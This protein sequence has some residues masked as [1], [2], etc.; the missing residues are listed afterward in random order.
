MADQRNITFGMSFGLNEANEQI[1]NIINNLETVKQDMIFVEQESDE[2]GTRIG[3]NAQ[4]AGN[5]LKDAGAQ[6]ATAGM[7]I[8]DSANA[9]GDAWKSIGSNAESMSAAII[10]SA[11]TAIKQTNSI[12]STVKAGLE[13]A[14]GYSE[15]RFKSFTTSMTTGMKKIATIAKNP[16]QTIKDGL[17]GALEKAR[18][19]LEDVEDEADKTGN[20]MENV[21]KAGK[22]TGT[23]IKTAI[24]GA[25]GKLVALKAGFELIKKGIEATKN[26]ASTLIEAGTSADTL[27][28]KFEAV[29]ANDTGVK[30]WSENFAAGINRSKSE[31]QEFLVSNKALYAELGITGETATDLSKVTTSL[32]YDLGA[33]FKMDDAEA[34]SVLQDYISGNTNALAEYGI[35]IDDAILKQSALQMGISSNI[36]E[37]SD[38]EA[39]QIRMNALLE[40]STSIQ[41][42]AANGELGYANGTKAITAKLTDLKETLGTKFEPIFTKVVGKI[43]ELW[44]KIEPMVISLFDNMESGLEMAAPA[45]LDLAASALPQVI[46]AFSQ[47][48]EA[49]APIGSVLLNLATTALP[50]LLKA[51]GPVAS[52][53]ASLATTILPPLGSIIG[54]LVQTVI[55]PFVEIVTMI[56]EKAITPLMPLVGTIADAILPVIESGLQALLPI[57]GAVLP[58]LEPICTVIGS[59]V[60][61]LGKIAAYAASGIGTVIEKVAGLFNGNGSTESIELPHNALGT[62][63]FQGGWTHIN[64]QGGEVAYLPGGSTIIP[65]DKSQQLI[66]NM[67]EQSGQNIQVSISM[68]VTISGNA[69]EKTLNELEERMHKIIKEDAAEIFKKEQDKQNSKI[70]IQEGYT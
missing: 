36:D 61:F 19:S 16:I 27:K 56:T 52:A 33:A 43:L 70:A 18:E 9:A 45:L 44:P 60:E 57:L 41:Q 10:K 35:Q 58:I 2:V 37:L 3:E 59:I 29:F 62:Q 7:Q 13:G 40:N 46:G 68:P 21:G 25:V 47:L 34:L 32:A 30:Q 28:E 50:P 53:I 14:I 26:L 51:L 66:N 64:E 65:S 22:D 15:K 38:A 55:P 69:D 49:G 31:V 17:A 11:G 1:D 39:A 12:G 20:K 5:S 4:K 23:S 54:K 24:S 6:A 67:S 8:S 42:Q 63:N 48:M